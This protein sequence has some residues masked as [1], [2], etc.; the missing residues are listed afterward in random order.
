[1]CVNVCVCIDVSIHVYVY[2]CVGVYIPTCVYMDVCTQ[3]HVCACV[4]RCGGVHMCVYVC[5]V[6]VHAYMY[7]QMHMGVCTFV[8]RCVCMDAGVQ[9]CTWMCGVHMCVGVGAHVCAWM[10]VHGLC[11]HVYAWTCVHM[12][13]YPPVCGP[14]FL[15]LHKRPPLSPLILME[16]PGNM[17]PQTLRPTLQCSGLSVSCRVYHPGSKIP[18]HAD[19]V[20]QLGK[21]WMENKQVRSGKWH[22][23][24]GWPRD[25]SRMLEIRRLVQTRGCMPTKGHQHTGA[26]FISF[27]LV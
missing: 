19:I 2:F 16:K 12:S 8:Y 6:C 10:Y 11:V 14:A 13:V 23:E 24:L 5:A 4:H 3:V 7:A 22:E 26:S 9:V 25:R 21:G 17:I 15:V 18:N 1:M 20:C 27:T